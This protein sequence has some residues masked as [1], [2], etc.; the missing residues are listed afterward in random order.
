MKT[1]WI[2]DAIKHPGKLHEELHVPEGKKIPTA[3][4]KKAEH[5]KDPVL[6]KRA[7]LA[8][9]LRKISKKK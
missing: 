6:K 7:V 1:N 2:K 3:K 4:L 9:T 8:Q 5:S